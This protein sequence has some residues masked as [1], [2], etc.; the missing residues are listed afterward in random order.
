AEETPLTA[1][2]LARILA[3]AGV[4][5]GVVNVLLTDEP[6]PLVEQALADDRVRKLS[7]TGSTGVG[8]LLLRQAAGRIVDS[9]MELGG[10]DPFIVCADADIAAAVDGAMLA[11]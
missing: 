2:L 10:N 5:E 8:S 4:P 6:G 7:F 3:D 11:K 1:L 9:S